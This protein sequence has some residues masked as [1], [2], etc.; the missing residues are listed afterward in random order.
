MSSSSPWKH[1]TSSPSRQVPGEARQARK[2]G[3]LPPREHIQSSPSRQILEEFSR[4]LVED[5]RHFTKSLDELAD[6]QEVLHKAALAESWKEHEKIRES[7]ER[8]REQ[9]ELQIQ[10]EKQRRE[11]HEQ[12]KLE[13]VRRLAHQE[14]T[15]IEAR[16]RRRRIEQAEREEATRRA[17]LE[18]ERKLAETR[19]RIVE[20]ERQQ[21]A[22]ENAKREAAQAK[23]AQQE[24]DRKARED[25]AAAAAADEAKAVPKVEPPSQNGTSAAHTPQPPG[26]A[27]ATNSTSAAIGSKIATGL[28]S[29]SAITSTL[30]SSRE[31]LQADHE[32][33]L[34][35][36]QR[37]KEI[38]KYVL[39]EAKKPEVMQQ[40]GTSKDFL[41]EKRRALRSKIGMM[42]LDKANNKAPVS[43]VNLLLACMIAVSLTHQMYR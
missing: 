7:A 20:A 42:A 17:K 39:A 21:Q 13:E 4:L 19:D 32:A 29:Q 16:E 26:N 6:K 27:Q 28:E 14:K 12:H 25:A 41:S 38:R 34:A 33:Y 18:E 36:H 43:R 37:L 10:I 2:N 22:E 40:Y 35:L 23:V 1:D 5:E 30:V 11:A 15:D 31:G 3:Y 24:K 8:A 9:V